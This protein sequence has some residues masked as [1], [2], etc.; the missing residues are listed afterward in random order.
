MTWSLTR[1]SALPE[2]LNVVHALIASGDG[3]RFALTGSSARKLKRSGVNLLAGRA[4]MR[5][6]HPFML[7]ELASSAGAGRELDTCLRL[8]VVPPSQPRMI[9]RRPSPRTSPSTWSRK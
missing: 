5:T 8:G 4:A 3:H 9:L 6:M 2:L 7:G 1:F